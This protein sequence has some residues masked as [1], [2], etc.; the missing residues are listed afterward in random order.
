M[1]AVAL[2]LRGCLQISVYKEA[3]LRTLMFPDNP[4]SPGQRWKLQ[5]VETRSKQPTLE[6]QTL[7]SA[8]KISCSYHWNF[9]VYSMLVKECVME[10]KIWGFFD[11]HCK[12]SLAEMILCGSFH[13]TSGFEIEN[14]K[15]R[16]Y[17]NNYSIMISW[18]MILTK[19]GWLVYFSKFYYLLCTW[20]E[21]IN[22]VF[23]NHQWN[24]INIYK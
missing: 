4:A 12:L 14:G 15:F 23:K 11:I 16:I 19:T 10:M 7:E 13:I 9:D 2:P 1:K 8:W 21:L 6:G 5:S 20:I 24:L 18:L 22:I 3:A 17:S